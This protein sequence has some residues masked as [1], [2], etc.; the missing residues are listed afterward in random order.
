MSLRYAL[1]RVES[2]VEATIASTFKSV[3][4][5]S[6]ACEVVRLGEFPVGVVLLRCNTRSAYPSIRLSHAV[7]S[8]ICTNAFTVHVQYRAREAAN[9]L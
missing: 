9:V 4:K 8:F 7:F 3:E 5:R 1:V 2:V 6:W